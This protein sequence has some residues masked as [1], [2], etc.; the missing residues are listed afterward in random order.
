MVDQGNY[1][2]F[3][4]VWFDESDNYVT[5]QVITND[6][7]SLPLFTEAGS[8]EVNTC[9]LLLSGNFGDFI[10]DNGTKPVIE[11]F[12]RIR[13]QLDDLAGNTYSR[14]FEVKPAQVPSKKQIRW[15]LYS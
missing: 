14:Y 11:Q 1:K 2:N 10:T 12:D 5:T 4:V 7:I 8:G 3:T 9:E 13:I 6:V 15:W